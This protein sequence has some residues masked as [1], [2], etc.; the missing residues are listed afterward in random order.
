MLSLNI[1]SNEKLNLLGWVLFT[2]CA[3]AYLV[4]SIGNFWFELGSTFFLLA[5]F[6]F[7]I[8]FFRKNK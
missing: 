6:V 1:M 4:G 7:L 2:L 5:C 3:V 8:P